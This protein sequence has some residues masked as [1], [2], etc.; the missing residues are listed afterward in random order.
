LCEER[1]TRQPQHNRNPKEAVH[2][3]I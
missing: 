1:R 2:T 3:P